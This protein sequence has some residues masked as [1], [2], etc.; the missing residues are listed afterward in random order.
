MRRVAGHAISDLSC[1]G[2]LFVSRGKL[3]SILFPAISLNTAS[4]S[5]S[6]SELMTCV[7]MIQRKPP[8]D[9]VCFC[10]GPFTRLVYMYRQGVALQ[11]VL[12]QGRPFIQQV[13]LPLQRFRYFV[14]HKV[15][16]YEMFSLEL[17]V[18]R[19][20][21]HH[22][23]PALATS[24]FAYRRERNLR[25]TWT[26]QAK[27]QQDTNKKLFFNR[28]AH[29]AGPYHLTIASWIGFLSGSTHCL[30]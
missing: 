15:L 7:T 23:S 3:G 13:T 1:G 14:S 28:F 26:G 8:T 20:L 22:I 6:G 19:E 29:S 25:R 11:T 16:M 9:R 17:G 18:A 30:E 2:F 21:G 10:R 27:Q 4:S 12:S 5:L 24:E